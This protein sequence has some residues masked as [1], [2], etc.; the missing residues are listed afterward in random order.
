MGWWNF[1]IVGV[2]PILTVTILYIVKRKMLW[3]APFASTALAFITYTIAL[4]PISIADIFNNNEW[5]V[6]F[7]L[8]LFI[9]FVI[10]LVLTVIA[11]FIAYILK[12]K[13]S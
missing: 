8:V 1:L 12:R 2:L 9:H 5:R 4:A 10:V 13:N 6:F 11:Y 7:I 3:A